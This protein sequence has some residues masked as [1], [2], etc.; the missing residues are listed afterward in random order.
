MQSLYISLAYGIRGSVGCHTPFLA[1]AP[2][3]MSASGQTRK[4][5]HVFLSDQY[6]EGIYDKGHLSPEFLKQAVSYVRY[7]KKD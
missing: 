7:W 4:N 6:H 3:G 2:G 1:L 5:Y